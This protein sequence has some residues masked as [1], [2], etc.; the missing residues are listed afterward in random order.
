MDVGRRIS[1]DLRLNRVSASDT[2]RN[3]CKD[4]CREGVICN[5]N[6]EHEPGADSKVR[7]ECDWVGSDWT[8]AFVISIRLEELNEI[9]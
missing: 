7:C 1:I 3:R 6:G 2:A 9:V 8:A 4:T 5:F